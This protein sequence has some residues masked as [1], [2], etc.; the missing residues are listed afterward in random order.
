MFFIQCPSCRCDRQ[1]LHECLNFSIINITIRHKF[2]W[3]PDLCQHLLGVYCLKCHYFKWLRLVVTFWWADYVVHCL[4]DMQH[5]W[6][7]LRSL[8]VFC[9]CLCSFLYATRH[10]I[11]NL[12]KYF[13][14]CQLYAGKQF[15]NMWNISRNTFHFRQKENTLKEHAKEK[16]DKIGVMLGIFQ[17]K[18]GTIGVTLE[19]FPR[20]LFQLDNRWVCFI[21]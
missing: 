8:W 9:S 6:D 1:Y 11:V 18:T 5:T 3:W 20:K 7:T 13:P 21:F 19:T 14:M 12:D 15:T 17:R 10:V 2:M 16:P 4:I